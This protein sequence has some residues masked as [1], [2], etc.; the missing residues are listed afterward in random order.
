MRKGKVI[1]VVAS[2][3]FK[4][5]VK[6]VASALE[7]DESQF[8]RDTLREKIENLAKRNPKIAQILEDEQAA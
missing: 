7:T 6:A 1:F 3:S 4:N 8:V 2:E 5:R